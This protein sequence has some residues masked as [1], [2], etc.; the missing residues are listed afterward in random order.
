M[1]V[2]LHWTS[3]SETDIT[4]LSLVGLTT[5]RREGEGVAGRDFVD[6]ELTEGSNPLQSGQR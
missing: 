2:N 6:G 4:R 5:W 1:E 3:F